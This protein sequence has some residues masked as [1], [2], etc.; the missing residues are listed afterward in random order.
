MVWRG[1]NCGADFPD[2]AGPLS[3]LVLAGNLAVRLGGK[4]IVFD[5]PALK[6]SEPAEANQFLHREYRKGWTL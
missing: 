6:C 3:E 5:W 1:A 2:F 4:K